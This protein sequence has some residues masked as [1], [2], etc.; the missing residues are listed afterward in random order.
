VIANLVPEPV[1]EAGLGLALSFGTS[2]LRI[3]QSLSNIFLNFAPVFGAERLATTSPIAVP[4][5]PPTTNFNNPFMS[6]PFAERIH[7][8]PT[9]ESDDQSNRR[10]WPPEHAGG[11]GIEGPVD[12]TTGLDFTTKEECGVHI[13]SRVYGSRREHAN[14]PA[15]FDDRFACSNQD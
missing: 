3:R 12:V 4:T 5:A 2:C 11:Q 15:I 8:L 7:W 9:N 14:C 13:T 10:R 6:F 1:L